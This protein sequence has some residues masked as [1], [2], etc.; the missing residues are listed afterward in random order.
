MANKLGDWMIDVGDLFMKEV[1][2]DKLL[3][4]TIN[5]YNANAMT[6]SQAYEMTNKLATIYSSCFSKIVKQFKDVDV[7]ELKNELL[8]DMFVNDLSSLL[9]DACSLVN[10]LNYNIAKQ[11]NVN[12]G[13]G[14]NPVKPKLNKDRIIQVAEQIRDSEDIF[15]SIDG[16][17][18]N[19]LLSTTDDF[20]Q[21]NAEYDYEAGFEVTA[22]RHCEANA[23]SWCQNLAEESGV[24][25]EQIKNKGN[26][27]W[28]RHVGCI[29]EIEIVKEKRIK[30]KESIRRKR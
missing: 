18:R 7:E 20:I 19:L 28:R 17:S 21:Q 30:T 2:K 25:Y 16:F 22:Y 5:R 27:F 15:S 14:L 1:K 10:N 11:A 24:P 29:C 13:I 23:C 8:N 6:Q 9:N 4:L 3:W 26:D 12:I